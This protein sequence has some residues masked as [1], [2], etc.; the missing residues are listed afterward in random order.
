MNSLLGIGNDIVTKGSKV[1]DTKLQSG[2]ST[3]DLNYPVKRSIIF[4]S[5]LFLWLSQ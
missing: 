2:H 3:L 1:I 4:E 5:F